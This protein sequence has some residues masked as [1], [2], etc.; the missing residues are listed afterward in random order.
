MDIKCD[1]KGAVDLA[2]GW[3]V[4]GQTK[5]IDIRLNF[6][7]ELKENKTVRVTWIDTESN[8]GD[9]HTKNLDPKTFEKHM[10]VHCGN[11]EHCGTD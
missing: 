3:S 8:T 9:I 1:N 6:L 5:H 2:N 11:N 7:R 10:R 4:G